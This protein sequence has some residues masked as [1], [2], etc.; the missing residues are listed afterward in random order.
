MRRDDEEEK[1]IKVIGNGQIDDGVKNITPAD[2]I[3]AINY[4]FNL[5]AWCRQH[6]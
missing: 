6:R 3:S 5:L 1:I 2:I 4:F